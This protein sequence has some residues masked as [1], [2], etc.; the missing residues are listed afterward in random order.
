MC[1]PNDP[2]YD[3][4]KK[5]RAIASLWAW[6]ALLVG[7]CYV[8]VTSDLAADQARGII[9][10]TAHALLVCRIGISIIPPEYDSIILGFA[11][12]FNKRSVYAVYF[13]NRRVAIP[14]NNTLSFTILFE[15]LQ[16]VETGEKECAVFDTAVRM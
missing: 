12:K 16:G 13:T 4:I 3:Q 6:S 9:M 7:R 2:L 11:G 1:A 8:C 14:E 15:R 10:R 5:P